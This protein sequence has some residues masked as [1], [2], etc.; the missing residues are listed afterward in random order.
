L[1][2]EDLRELV[3]GELKAA[4]FEV[5]NAVDRT[6]TAIKLAVTAGLLVV[7]GLVL[8]GIALAELIRHFDIAAWVAYGITGLLLCGIST[9]PFRRAVAAVRALSQEAPLRATLIQARRDVRWIENEVA[10]ATRSK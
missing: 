8:V 2:F 6:G 4:T 5:T 7:P 9:F 10:S 3:V 1:A